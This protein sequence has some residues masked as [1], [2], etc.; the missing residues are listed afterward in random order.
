MDSATGRKTIGSVVKAFDVIELLASVDCDLG[1]TEIGNRLD[2]GVSATYH[3]MATL[4]ML[5]VVEQD[6]DTK[7]YRLGLRLW[8][9]GER[10]KERN[11]LISHFRP[12]LKRIRDVTGETTNLTFLDGNE[13]IYV[14]QEEIGRA[15]V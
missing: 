12:Y 2:A 6:P 9:I 10:A 13:I 5:R 4:N 14:A 1:V 3:L 8:A 15:H 11:H 7:K